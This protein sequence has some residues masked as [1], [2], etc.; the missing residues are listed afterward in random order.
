MA[1][2]PS[3]PLLEAYEPLAGNDEGAKPS[4]PEEKPSSSAPSD[5][6]QHHHQQG[7][8]LDHKCVLDHPNHGHQSGY[9]APPPLQPHVEPLRYPSMAPPSDTSVVYGFPVAGLP[10]S[11]PHWHTSLCGCCSDPTV[12]LIG[13]CCPCVLFGKIAEHL[14]DGATSC[15]AAATVWYI[16]QQF[17]ACGW[18]YSHGY[19]DKL[20][21][22]YDLKRRPGCDCIVHCCCWPC[23]F[24][25][26]Y[27]EIEIRRLKSDAAQE[28]Y[29]TLVT[30]PQQVMRH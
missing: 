6:R 27:R 7:Y 23:A 2:H 26:E 20:R 22:R 4:R 30:P 12:C 8:A 29:A 14:D 24:C 3:A 21:S 13:W 15:V 5:F 9:V 1:F 18:I 17:T 28:R 11:N 10:H 16:L 19:R 25:Q